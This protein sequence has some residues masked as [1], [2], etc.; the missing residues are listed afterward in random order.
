FPFGGTVQGVPAKAKNKVGAAELIK[1]FF[2]TEKGSEIMRD[3][4]GNFSPYKPVYDIPNFYSHK[5]EH[6]AGQDVMAV[7]DTDIFPKIKSVR[8][9]SKYDQDIDDAMNVAMQTINASEGG[10]V[11]VDELVQKM[12]DDIMTKQPDIKA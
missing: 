11:S 2:M 1:F 7:F 9:P 4:K 8:L 10:S 12:Q 5:D 3:Q 6:F